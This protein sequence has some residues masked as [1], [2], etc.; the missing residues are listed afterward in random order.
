MKFMV[1]IQAEIEAASP[2][3]AAIQQAVNLFGT[4]LLE[5]DVVNMEDENDTYTVYLHRGT[6]VHSKADN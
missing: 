3:D 2:R 1:L 4:E 6:G 5:V